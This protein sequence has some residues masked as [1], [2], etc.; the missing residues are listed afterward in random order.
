MTQRYGDATCRANGAEEATITRSA[1]GT[2][3]VDAGSDGSVDGFRTEDRLVVRW[4]GDDGRAGNTWVEVPADTDAPETRYLQFLTPGTE[5]GWLFA[6]DGRTLIDAAQDHRD[7]G[8]ASPQETDMGALLS[9]TTEGDEVAT[10]RLETPSGDALTPPVVE[11]RRVRIE[12]VDPQTFDVT[13]VPLADQ[14]VARY[15]GSSFRLADGCS[16][17]TED[18]R[19]RILACSIEVAG[20][21]TVGEWLATVGVDQAL[22]DQGTCT[23]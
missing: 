15:L 10:A 18:E 6:I 4:P 16:D 22:F 2:L 1:D 11:A 19:A 14:P 12:R 7:T 20:D 23:R 9:W 17:Y 8:D 3:V 21:A 13:A 5:V